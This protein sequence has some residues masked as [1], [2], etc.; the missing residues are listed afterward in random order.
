[1]LC[2]QL[3][4]WYITHNWNYGILATPARTIVKTRLNNP[5]RIKDLEEAR[6]EF[7]DITKE[8]TKIAK[9]Q[10]GGAVDLLSPNRSQIF[11]SSQ[12]YI[13]DVDKITEA[14]FEIIEG[15]GYKL[16]TTKTD[17]KKKVLPKKSHL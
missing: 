2:V 1:M 9:I 7:I 4:F 5:S 15:I 13:K 10:R 11:E 3:L 16:N 8:L 14:I 6:D 17:F 12:V